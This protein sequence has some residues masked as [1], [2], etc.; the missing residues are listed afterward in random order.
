[1]L[2]HSVSDKSAPDPYQKPVLPQLDERRLSKIAVLDVGSNSVRLVVF[3]GV[4][5]SPS[6]FYNEKLM[7]SLGAGLATTGHLNPEG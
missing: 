5:R 2:Q 3:D 4:A 6:Y 1:M 7:C